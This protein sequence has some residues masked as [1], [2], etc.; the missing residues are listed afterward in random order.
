MIYPIPH[1]NIAN[2]DE[3]AYWENFFT[4]EELNILNNLPEWENTR[5][6]RIGGAT[7]LSIYDPSV[8]ETEISWFQPSKE[9]N[10]FWEKISNVIANVNSE[11]FG[12]DLTGFYES[13][14]L[15]YYSSETN[16]FYNW[17]ID[18]CGKDRTVPRKLSV[19]ILISDPSEFDGGQLEVKTVSD[20]PISLEQKRGRAWFFPS[21]TLH[22]VSP[23]TR[24][25]RKSIV[26]WSG[27]P[28]FK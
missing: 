16:G 15:G 22:R 8:R 10:F 4:L 24:G 7:S 14:Q 19:S 5:K 6:A 21:Y 26:L 18:G 9:T 27:G 13:A 12:F 3:L 17:H 25:V 2:K 23:V 1:R 11:F 20:N 28:A